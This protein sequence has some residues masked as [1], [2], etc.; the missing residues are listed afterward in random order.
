MLHDQFNKDKHFNQEVK[1][2]D[3]SPQQL[4]LLT[5]Q[6]IL[7]KSVDLSRPDFP[8]VSNGIGEG[9]RDIYLGLFVGMTHVKPS[10]TLR[11]MA[12]ARQILK[13]IKLL[14]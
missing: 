13:T 5:K 3:W 4:A 2:I 6:I 14:L 7:G 10:K 8:Q 1:Y 11:T 12:S 9:N